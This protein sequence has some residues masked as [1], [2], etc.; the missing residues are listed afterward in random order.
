MVV[1]KLS[2]ARNLATIQEI[3][4]GAAR[5]LAEADGASF[6]LREEGHCHCV[7]E[8]AIEPLWKGRRCL[9]DASI[10]GWT[11]LHRSQVMIPD[12]HEDP[13]IAAD[14]FRA[15]FVKSLVM[16]PIRTLDPIGVIGVFW[17]EHRKLEQG[18]LD[19][20]QALADSTAVAME[21][22]AL[23]GELEERVRQRTLALEAA[24]EEIHELSLQDDLTGLR[25]RRGFYLL[26]QQERKQAARSGHPAFVIFI[27][28]DGLKRINDEQGHEVGDE[29]LCSAARVLQTTFRDTDIVARLGGD[30]FCV[31]A[32]DCRCEPRELQSRVE[33]NIEAF[34]VF[35]RGRPFTLAASIGIEV[36]GP[37][38]T[39]TLE[40]LVAQADE[41][42]YGEKKN[43]RDTA[44][45]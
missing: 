29:L 8:D 25:N 43:R 2:L 26:A 17:A 41:R 13:R 42:M 28:I 11:I 45:A 36:C 19:L 4:L 32:T 23:M 35:H 12:I 24:R 30:E 14:E 39:R 6:V 15:T 18:D 21:N 31:F 7:E 3:V 16:T 40:Q 10:S 9:L 38:D 34:N 33:A 20:L 37:Q 22:V 44:T 5:E 1:Q 27:D